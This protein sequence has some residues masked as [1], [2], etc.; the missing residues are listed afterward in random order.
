MGQFYQRDDWE[1]GLTARFSDS[2]NRLG[3]SEV[4]TAGYVVLDAEA[5]WHWNTL[6]LSAGAKNLLDKTYSDFLN[7]N[8][9][10]SDPFLADAPETLNLPLNEPGRSFWLGVNYTF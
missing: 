3:P 1:T 5:A 4:A 2:Q 7:R 6:T 10:A 9:S 8:R